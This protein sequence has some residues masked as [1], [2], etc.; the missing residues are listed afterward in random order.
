MLRAARDFT[1]ESG[2]NNVIFEYA[3]AEQLPF[4]DSM[5]DLVTCRVTAHHFR[6]GAQ[7][8][9]ESGR[10]LKTGGMLVVEDHVLPEDKDLAGYVE[11]FEKM[12]DPSHNRAFSANEWRQMY[13]DNGLGV[14]QVELV[15]KRHI[16]YEWAERQSPSRQVLEDLEEMVDRAPERVLAWIQPECFGS[17]Q[18]SFTNYH[19]LISGHKKAYE[20]QYSNRYDKRT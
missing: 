3:D 5:F 1:A 7:F 15:L 12:R 14:C 9:K 19:I 17:E 4:G 2:A 13:Q 20:K 6:R 18:A 8:V 11:R 16:F 10:V